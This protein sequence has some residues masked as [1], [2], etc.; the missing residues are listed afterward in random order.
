MRELTIDVQPKRAFIYGVRR[1]LQNTILHPVVASIVVLFGGW[2]VASFFVSEDF[3][4]PPMAVWRELVVIF[5]TGTPITDIG[6]T[7]ERISLAW[8]A[9]MLVGVAVGVLMASKSVLNV[10]F[11]DAVLLLMSIPLL[12]WSL[13]GVLWF[14]GAITASIIAGM[15]VA[16]PHAAVNVYE[17]VTSVERDLVQMARVYRQPTRKIL[18]NIMIPSMMPFIFASGRQAFAQIWKTIAILE[19]FGASTGMGWQIESAYD[20]N[21]VPGVIAWVLLF[22]LIMLIIEIVGFGQTS[23]YVFRWRPKIGEVA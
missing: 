18:L 14:G 5:T 8:I 17:G 23:K 19:I 2:L 7:L 13:L 12:V 10:L 16:F 3:V 9:S 22:I 15:M 4:P 20:R 1:V 6:I 21:S 11:R